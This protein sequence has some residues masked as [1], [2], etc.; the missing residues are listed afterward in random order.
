LTGYT[1]AQPA[2]LTTGDKLKY[3]GSLQVCILISAPKTG[4][5]EPPTY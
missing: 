2:E 4:F 1:I 3:K 5:L